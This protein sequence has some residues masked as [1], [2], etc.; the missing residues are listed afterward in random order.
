M[1]PASLSYG[2][3]LA[4]V[5]KFGH[6]WHI[7]IGGEIRPQALPDRLAAI[8]RLRDIAAQQQERGEPKQVAA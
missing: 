2:A 6:A 3:E 5:V 7:Y 4:G 1:R 8:D